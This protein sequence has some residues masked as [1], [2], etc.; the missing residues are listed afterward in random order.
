MNEKDIMSTL[1]SWAN[2]FGKEELKNVY[3]NIM[4]MN[5]AQNN[6]IQNVNTKEGNI[7]I[8]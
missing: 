6:S 1:S 4:N 8:D 5:N 7:Q 2:E 3:E